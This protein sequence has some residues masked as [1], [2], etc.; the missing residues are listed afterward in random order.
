MPTYKRYYHVP[1]REIEKKAVVVSVKDNEVIVFNE[2]GTEI[3]KFIKSERK[4]NEIVRHVLSLFD[5][6][7]KTVKED[8]ESFLK[9]L[10]EREMLDVK[11]EIKS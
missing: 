5:S 2:V 9:D 10:Q 4:I 11:P 1:W 8:V 7:K 3:W 6:D